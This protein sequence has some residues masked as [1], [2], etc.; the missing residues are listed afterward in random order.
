M[1]D[2]SGLT[3]EI[4]QSGIRSGWR[5][6]GKSASIVLS[7]RVSLRSDYALSLCFGAIPD[8]KPLH[9]FAGI[10]LRQRLRIPSKT[11]FG[12]F[13]AQGHFRYGSGRR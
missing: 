3:A 7:I 6:I 10:A 2:L 4:V 13:H 8:A 11:Q 12:G 5:A 9:T 1:E